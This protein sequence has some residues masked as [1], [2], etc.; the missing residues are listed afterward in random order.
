MH[1]P[2]TRTQPSASTA[3]RDLANG[4]M[5]QSEP[6]WFEMLLHMQHL[7]GPWDPKFRLRNEQNVSARGKIRWDRD[8]GSRKVTFGR[9]MS[10]TLVLLIA[11]CILAGMSEE[12]RT[13]V[14]YR[15][16]AKWPLSYYRAVIR[17]LLYEKTRDP[18]GR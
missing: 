10:L 14:A 18:D 8:K 11:I 2:S 5:P 16:Y 17:C 9:D 7:E 4:R 3:K 15:H 6:Q 13:R 1:R 12:T